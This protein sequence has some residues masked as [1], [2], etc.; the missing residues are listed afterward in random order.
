MR[1]NEARRGSNK[2]PSGSERVA[3]FL[4]STSMR[5]SL[6]YLSISN[7]CE[8]QKWACFSKFP[9]I[10]N[11][12]QGKIVQ[13]CHTDQFLHW[14]LKKGITNL[15][16]SEKKQNIWVVKYLPLGVWMYAVVPSSN[17]TACPSSSCKLSPPTMY[18]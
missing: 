14:K 9:F 18:I 16:S 1:W 4:Y 17:W 7:C 11:W 15:K 10:Q 8:I 2:K 13:K 6:S 3:C 12:T 5:V